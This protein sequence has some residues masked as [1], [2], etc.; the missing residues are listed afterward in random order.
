K[1]VKVVSFVSRKICY[2][3]GTIQEWLTVKGV[4]FYKV[5]ISQR[6]LLIIIALLLFVI[7]QTDFNPIIKS[8]KQQM[9][10]DFMYKYTG[11]PSEETQNEIDELEKQLSDIT[12]EYIEASKLYQAGEIS[13]DEYLDVEFKYNAYENDRLFLSQIKEQTEYLNSVIR[14][15][16]IDVWYVNIYC[17]N[18]L[19]D[20][21][22]SIQDILLIIV[23]VLLCSGIF[24]AEKRLGMDSMMRQTVNG[25]KTVFTGK[26]YVAASLTFFLFVIITGIRIAE[27]VYV[28]GVSGLNAP[29]QSLPVLSFI[30]FKCSILV[31]LLGVYLM[32]FIVLLAIAVLVCMFSAKTGQKATIGLSFLLSLPAVLTIVGV[33]F[34]RYLSIINILSIVPFLLQVKSIAIVGIVILAFVVVGIVSLIGGY[35][36]WCIT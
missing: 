23:I 33:E 14:E 6:G 22:D 20:E 31:F 8:G 5:L 2:L 11:S 15:K 34:F 19:L 17:Y 4:E 28:Y 1:F 30:P 36:K 24:S 35:R 10:Y 12:D 29:V 25:R 9:Y 18:H 3:V 21:S 16:N 26:I 27:S 32:K 13:T 7:S